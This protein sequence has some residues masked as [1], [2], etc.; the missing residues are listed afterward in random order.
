MLGNSQRRMLRQMYP[1]VEGCID[2]AMS[3]LQKFQ[4]DP[5]HPG[6]GWM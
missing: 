3:L 5:S 4:V 1:W 6:E 2:A